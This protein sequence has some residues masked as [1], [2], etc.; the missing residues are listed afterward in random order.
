MASLLYCMLYITYSW[1]KQLVNAMFNSTRHL[2]HKQE[3]QSSFEWMT[4]VAFEKHIST[5]VKY[6]H[7][8]MQFNRTSRESTINNSL[9]K[10]KII[11]NALQI[12]SDI[13]ICSVTRCLHIIPTFTFRKRSEWHMAHTTTYCIVNRVKLF[14]LQVKHNKKIMWK[15]VSQKFSWLLLLKIH[16]STTIIIYYY[17]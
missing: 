5:S 6:F 9:Q 17:E 16:I 2:M 14:V 12:Y 4:V 10:R 7:F 3:Q 1:I 11:C 8:V 13:T 15:T